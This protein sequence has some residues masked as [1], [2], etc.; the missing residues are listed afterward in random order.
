MPLPTSGVHG[1]STRI[2]PESRRL[3]GGDHSRTLI[4]KDV[5]ESAFRSSVLRLLQEESYRGQQRQGTGKGA[6]GADG[7][8]SKSGGCGSR[9]PASQG[10]ARAQGSIEGLG[11]SERH[12]AAAAHGSSHLGSLGK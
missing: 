3:V 11:A 12:S 4:E 9:G 2:T 7:G 6:Q 8:G 5:V 10:S 1:N